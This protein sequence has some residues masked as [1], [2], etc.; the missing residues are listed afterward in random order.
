MHATELAISARESFCNAKNKLEMSFLPPA[1]S[2]N[3]DMLANEK[4]MPPGA[5]LDGKQA[6]YSLFEQQTNQ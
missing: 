2:P 1:L 6:T 4:I 3:V 5:F